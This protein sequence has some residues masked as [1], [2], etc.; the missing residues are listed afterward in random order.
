MGIKIAVNQLKPP[1]LDVDLQNARDYLDKELRQLSSLNPDWL[2]FCREKSSIALETV[3][4]ILKQRRALYRQGFPFEKKD[5]LR[6][7]EEQMKKIKAVYLAFFSLSKGLVYEIKNSHLDVFV[8]LMLEPEFAEN[9]VHFLLAFDQIENTDEEMAKMLV[10]H[11]KM[12][13]MDY[14]LASCIDGLPQWA[15]KSFNYMTLRHS[16]SIALATHWF[17]EKKIEAR[18]VFPV[19][20]LFNVEQGQVWLDENA[21]NEE[22]LF[23]RLLLDIK[24][25]QEGRSFWFR[26]LL[27]EESLNL[28]KD[29]SL[30][31]ML[32]ERK[33]PDDFDPHCKHA[34]IKLALSGKVSW[35]MRAV[36][37][38][39]TCE[40]EEGAPWLQALYILY[41]K[42]SPVDPQELG[43]LY[44]WPQALMALDDWIAHGIEEGADV[45]GDFL[46]LG[47]PLCYASTLKALEDP[48]IDAQFRH[49]LWVQLCLY[50][51]VF[52]FW[53]PFMPAFQQAA[54]FKKL[55]TLKDPSYCFEKRYPN[56]VMG[57]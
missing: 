6:L 2:C 49:W 36:Q 31:A 51:R 52:I 41:G 9:S 53:D 16:L 10:L 24:R 17:K 48:F 40:E 12:P 46:R 47:E 54:V 29:L 34:P 7:I 5:Y 1:F 27:E 37:Y 39:K 44:E 15:V 42:N 57:D 25:G 55:E 26:A 4:F 32:L 19:L 23:E 38:M 11:S 14:F 50:G 45:Q 30:F 20:S 56:A 3:S 22:C 33:K 35:V 13:D 28:S 18:I 21:R 8:W 43:V